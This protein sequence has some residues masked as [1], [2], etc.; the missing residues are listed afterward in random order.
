MKKINRGILAALDWNTN[1]WSNAATSE[2]IKNSTFDFVK[3]FGFSFTCLNFGNTIFPSDAKGIYQGLIPHL[4]NKQVNKDEASKVKIVFLKSKNYNDGNTYIVGFYAFPIFKP[5]QKKLSPLESFK[6]DFMYNIESKKEDIHLLKNFI[7]LS[8]EKNISKFLP[9]DKELGKRG[10]NYL[11]KQNV[12]LILD[13]MTELNPV[14]KSLSKLK[15][16]ILKS[17]L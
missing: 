2:D 12:E 3:T 5:T 13:K 10:Y 16:S 1:M 7:N 11:T 17:I 8:E 4:W 9:K 15:L 6:G 14:D